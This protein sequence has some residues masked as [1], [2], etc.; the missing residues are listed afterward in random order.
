MLRL[1]AAALA[2]IF[3]ISAASALVEVPELKSRVTDLT[4][5]LDDRQKQ[6]L[7]SRLAQLESDKGSQLA[8]LLVPTTQPEAIEQYSIRVVEQWQLGREAA[9]DGVL[10]LVAKDDRKLRIEVGRGLEGAIPDAVANRIVEDMIVPRFRAGDFTGGVAAGVDAIAALIRGEALP[11]VTR[12]ERG[13]VDG[14][15]I[16]GFII[17]TAV[18]GSMMNAWLGRLAGTG[19]TSGIAFLAG[20]VIAGSVLLGIFLAVACG[21]LALNMRAGGGGGWS[22]GGFGGGSSGGSFGG[23]FSGGGGSFGGGGAS[24]SW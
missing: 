11:E 3:A 23:G 16:A 19:L 6:E 8:V 17:V 22:S 1:A 7:E 12:P 4:G 24:G 20:W 10:L 5:T 18:L 2:L 21:L 13:Q 14:G 15:W 9:D